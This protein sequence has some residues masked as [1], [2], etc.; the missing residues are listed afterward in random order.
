[1]LAAC[2][3]AKPSEEPRVDAHIKCSGVQTTPGYPD[4]P[5][6]PD[7]DPDPDVNVFAGGLMSRTIQLCVSVCSV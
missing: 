3:D 7:L 4:I 2:P 6:F 5:K 1:M